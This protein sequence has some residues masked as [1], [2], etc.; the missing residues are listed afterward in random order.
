MALVEQIDIKN[1]K[2]HTSF[3]SK[4]LS[5]DVVVYGNNG[6]GKTNLLESLSFFSNSKGMRG[7]KLENFFQKKNDIQ[8]KFLKVD[9]W[10][11][12]KDYSTN[13][14]YELVNESISFLKIFL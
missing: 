1:F 2:S 5:K 12:Q 14:S 8:S 13:I 6:I 7:N 3:Q 4:I 10:L 11:Q 9:C